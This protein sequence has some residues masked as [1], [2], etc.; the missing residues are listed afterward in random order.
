MTIGKDRAFLN[1][2]TL[3]DARLSDDVAVLSV[4]GQPDPAALSVQEPGDQAAALRLDGEQNLPSTIKRKMQYNDSLS[5]CG[6]TIE[7][8]RNPSD[9]KVNATYPKSSNEMVMGA[10]QIE[11]V[12]MKSQ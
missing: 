4:V 11:D 9:W 2:D 1:V 5:V 10:Y 3:L 6:R 7:L 8:E 12:C